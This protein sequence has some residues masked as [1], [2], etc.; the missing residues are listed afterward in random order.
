MELS[1]NGLNP[2]LYLFF[3]LKY[4]TKEQ[5]SLANLKKIQSTCKTTTV[6]FTK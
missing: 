1:V 4:L 2:T 3:N 5:L 6:K